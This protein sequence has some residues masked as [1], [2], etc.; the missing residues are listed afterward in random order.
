MSKKKKIQAIANRASDLLN[1]N[2]TTFKEINENAFKNCTNLNRVV[3]SSN[4]VELP[5]GLFSGCTRLTTIVVRNT[6]DLLT[7]AKDAFNGCNLNILRFEIKEGNVNLSPQE[8]LNIRNQY[9]EAVKAKVNANCFNR[10]FSNCDIETKLLNGFDKLLVS[11]LKDLDPIRK[12]IVQ[13]LGLN[14]Y[15]KMPNVEYNGIL[16]ISSEE[17][18]PTDLFLGQSIVGTWY[19]HPK[20]NQFVPYTVDI[21]ERLL[22]EKYKDFVTFLF[23]QG[24]DSVDFSYKETKV[25][26]I[27]K[28]EIAKS[29]IN[30]K[31]S[32]NVPGNVDSKNG[33]DISDAAKSFEKT[34]KKEVLKS[35]AI[36]KVS[37]VLPKLLWYSKEELKELKQ[38]FENRKSWDYSI[39]LSNELRTDTTQKK[40]I[41]S[42]LDSIYGKL[43]AKYDKTQTV[44]LEFNY[45]Q[46]I[47]LYVTFGSET[48]N[49]PKSDDSE[50]K[51]NELPELRYLPK[52]VSVERPDDTKAL[53]DS[54]HQNQFVNLVGIGGMGKTCLANL[55]VK[56]YSKEY[57]NVV[58]SLINGSFYSDITDKDSQ[59][60]LIADRYKMS[61][62][63]KVLDSIANT[64]NEITGAMFHTLLNLLN[65]K[66]YKLQ[67]LW[68]IDVNETADYA[69]VREA[70]KYMF[71]DKHL[72]ENWRVLIVSRVAF[73]E[74][75][76]LR[77]SITRVE[78]L[79][80]SKDFLKQVFFHYLVDYTKDEDDTE[81][82]L[83]KNI[84]EDK[85]NNG[86]IVLDKILEV[87][88]EN[89]LLIEQLASY[90]RDIDT[91]D[92]QQILDLFVA[93]DE[94]GNLLPVTE[95]Q[96]I[97][98]H[99]EGQK[100]FSKRQDGLWSAYY[101]P[102][103]NMQ[104][105]LTVIMP[106]RDTIYAQ[107]QMSRKK[108]VAFTDTHYANPKSSVYYNW[109]PYGAK[110]YLEDFLGGT[111]FLVRD[112]ENGRY[113]FGNIDCLIWIVADN[114]ARLGTNHLFVDKYNQSDS[115]RFDSSRI[116]DE[117]SYKYSQYQ[118]LD[119][120]LL[121]SGPL[122]IH[123]R[124]DVNVNGVPEY[125]IDKGTMSTGLLPDD[126]NPLEAIKESNDR[127]RTFF[128]VFGEFSYPAWEKWHPG[129]VAPKVAPKGKL[130]FYF[131]SECLGCKNKEKTKPSVE[132]SSSIDNRKSQKMQ[133][134]LDVK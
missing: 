24:A 10:L 110:G 53:F 21:E 60:K 69:Q 77:N 11:K 78:D 7:I 105:R 89:P 57:G 68:I 132:K 67:N 106:G 27:T 82:Y 56:D 129:E 51:K 134:L 112:E 37:S 84:Y 97:L 103:Y 111:L 66:Y 116:Y 61:V 122:R 35:T 127:A 80:N 17:N 34:L 131:F 59:L 49:P 8:T 92:Q 95:A 74:K 79:T 16:L 43:D 123:H 125:T 32:D 85:V 62:G 26:S 22:V 128:S 13:I 102:E 87:L 1:Q 107:T 120:S 133:P 75:K 23:S 96:V 114:G 65:E 101:K 93:K 44:K 48:T 109:S 12:G 64:G 33:I 2:L 46:E 118:Y 119:G 5:S 108:S 14:D 31:T 117:K 91:K 30:A 113:S 9:F 4:I 52:D 98:S 41:D 63:D 88:F 70:L 6:S 15:K 40:T 45:D 100:V 130:Y 126:Y 3:L 83:K 54:L 71:S 73:I 19:W 81:R 115:L 55:L 42:S 18:L 39:S 86:E 76:E 25:E 28:D 90:L 20:R 36:P 47:K 58:Y 94:N 50:K 38:Q 72:N 104:Y 124:G 29:S 121:H 99:D